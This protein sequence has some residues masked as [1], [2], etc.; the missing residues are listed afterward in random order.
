M[1]QGY[2]VMW[3]FCQIMNMVKVY[4]FRCCHQKGKVVGKMASD[5]VFINPETLDFRKFPVF[6]PHVVWE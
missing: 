3:P 6:D 4:C 2:A 1:L 5:S